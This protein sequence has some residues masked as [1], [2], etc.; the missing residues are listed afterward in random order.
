MNSLRVSP[1]MTPR[2]VRFVSNE[3]IKV[4]WH[5]PDHDAFTHFKGGKQALALVRAFIK[6][7]EAKE[8]EV[9]KV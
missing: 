8:E 2:V 9:A 6:G 3:S 1:E 7:V 4:E 5:R